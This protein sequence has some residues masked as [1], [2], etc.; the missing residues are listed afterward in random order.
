M[1]N[2]LFLILTA[3]C[4]TASLYANSEHSSVPSGATQLSDQLI[5]VEG[6]AIRVCAFS[7]KSPASSN[8]AGY[9]TIK[10]DSDNTIEFVGVQFAPTVESFSKAIELHTHVIDGHNAKMNLVKSLSVPAKGEL[11][12]QPGKDHIMFMNITKPV[13]V[14]DTFLLTLIFKQGNQTFT[15]DAYFAVKSNED[16]A[17]KKCGCCKKKKA[18]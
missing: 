2:K 15:K 7:D 18:A 16:L 13:K 10:N 9:V 8:T 1:F 12:L 3:M 4:F 6:A 5:R 14:G 11:K 17:K